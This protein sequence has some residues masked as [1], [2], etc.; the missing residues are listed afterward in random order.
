MPGSNNPSEVA[1]MESKSQAS[2]KRDHGSVQIDGDKVR[3]LRLQRGWSQDKLAEM[4]NCNKKTIENAENLCRGILKTVNGIATALGVKVD[5]LILP[6]AGRQ[7]A[8]TIV[9]PLGLAPSRP[10][11][12]IGREGPIRDLIELLCLRGRDNTSVSHVLTA[13]RGG[14]GIGKTTVARELAHH[15]DV[16]AEFPEVLWIALGFRPNV[17]ACLRSWA[18]ALH[19]EEHLVDDEQASKRIGAVVRDRRMLLIIDDIW[20]D[21]DAKHFKVGGHRCA[22]LMTTRLPAVANRLAAAGGPYV[23]PGLD[24]DAAVELLE[25][26]A[27]NEVAQHRNLAF[28]LARDLGGLPLGLQVA[29]R[30][31]R[32]EGAVGSN[33]EVVVQE[34]RT[35]ARILRETPPSDVANE[36]NATVAAVFD[37]STDRLDPYA[38]DCFASLGAFAAEPRS[39]DLDAMRSVWRMEDPWPLARV[40]IDLG[41]LEPIGDG[42]FQIHE[43]LRMHARFLLHQ[44]PSSKAW[45]LR[46]SSGERAEI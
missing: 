34:L 32:A 44:S 6:F 8:A 29:G 24:L 42:R 7:P 30:L 38:R 17:L 15:P 1:K 9:A 19:I 27:P 45:Q 28:E 23:L 36:T 25:A 12:V 10:D 14:I 37:R 33:I 21:Q 46:S 16:I 41:L 3:A 18:N 35:T 40:F 2:R 43:L 39:F 31:L 13:L 26:L 11:M 20:D 4:A 22:T 5:D